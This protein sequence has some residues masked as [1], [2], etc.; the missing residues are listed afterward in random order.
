MNQEDGFIRGQGTKEEVWEHLRCRKGL[1]L[2]ESAWGWHSSSLPTS[3]FGSQ[4]GEKIG[5]CPAALG[6]TFW[7]HLDSAFEAG[8][9]PGVQALGVLTRPGCSRVSPLINLSEFILGKGTFR[10]MMGSLHLYVHS[11][12]GFFGSWKDC[13]RSG[14]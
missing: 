12:T 2:Q 7:P 11:L 10:R 9:Q 3:P 1:P 4:D 5:A 6:P 13:V 14:D 8:G